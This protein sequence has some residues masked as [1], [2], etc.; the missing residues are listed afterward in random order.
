MT[1]HSLPQVRQIARWAAGGLV[2]LQAL[3]IGILSA[4]S[5]VRR[6]RAPPAQF[7]HS[8]APGATVDGNHLKVYTYGQELY[9]DMLEA[10]DAAEHSIYLETFIWKGDELGQEFKRKLEHKAAAGVAVYLVYDSFANL[11]VSP[12][13]KDFSATIHVL[14][15]SKL[16]RVWYA[17]DPRRYARDHRKILVVD[18]ETAFVGGFNIGALY[19]TEWRDTHLRLRG[20][21]ALEL[22]MAFVDFWNSN[23]DD[24]P[25]I[26]LLHPRTWPQDLRVYR[27]DPARLV[28]PLRAM[29]LDAISRAQH[30]IYLTNAYFIPDRVILTALIDAANRGVDVRV[31][32]PWQSNHVTADW[33]ARGFFDQCLRNGVRIFGF[34]HAMIH[35]KTATIDGIWSTIGTANLD[36]LSLAG[37]FEIN[38][39]VRDRAFAATMEHI[40]N[41]DLTNAIEVTLA[42]WEHRS[43]LMRAGELILSPLRPLL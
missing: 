40:F 32:L 5:F 31:L 17:L 27:N 12:T 10:I 21:A 25:P 9:R 11:V 38:V 2:G 35:A 8:R 33:L 39:E 28:F 41:T 16:D 29:Y 4:M 22:G 36:R 3:V 30:H 42:D 43:V 26:P 18:G 19:A 6:R 15:Y 7:P 1:R 20:P 34:Q 24:Q 37:N 13:F 14:E 23:H